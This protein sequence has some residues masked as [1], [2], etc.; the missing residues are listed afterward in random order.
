MSNILRSIGSYMPYNLYNKTNILNITNTKLKSFDLISKVPEDPIYHKIKFIPH[1]TY[2]YGNPEHDIYI[3]RY[4]NGNVACYDDIVTYATIINNNPKYIE[5]RA[6]NIMNKLISAMIQ[7]AQ[8][9]KVRDAKAIIFT[10]QS[11]HYKYGNPTLVT[12]YNIA[13]KNSH[14]IIEYDLQNII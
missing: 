8:Y 14:I 13:N 9:N 11:M 6:Y 12:L 10:D 5:L 2:H 1:Q 4:F 3:A 7:S